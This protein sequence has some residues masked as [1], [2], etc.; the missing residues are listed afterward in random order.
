MKIREI[1]NML[2]RVPLGRPVS[3]STQTFTTREF[4]VVRLTTEQGITGVGYARGGELVRAAVEHELRPLVVG[5]DA[6]ATETLWD[7]VWRR[8]GLVGRRGAV[9]RALSALDIALWDIKAKAAGLPLYQL[10]GGAV[11]SVPAYVSGGYYRDG[12]TEQELA[13]EM[14]GYVERGFRAVKMRVGRLPLRQDVRRVAAVRAA[15]G[16][17]TELMVDAN[18]AYRSSAVAIAAGRAFADEGVSWLEEPLGLEHLAATA[19]VAA[20]LDLPIAGGEVESTRWAFRDIIEQ[21]VYDILQP[22]VTVVGGIS[23]W[24]KVAAL[25]ST[26][27]LA[28]APHYFFEVHAHLVAATPAAVCVEYFYPDSDI[29]TFDPLLAEPLTPTNGVLRLNE[30]PGIGLELD[31]TML[32]RLRVA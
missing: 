13:R 20:A 4:N 19:E 10:L 25:A 6:L 18:Q 17:E 26:W 15:I 21:K 8:T 29:I 23:E 30:R 12:E 14:A 32:A 22:D 1:E 5:R 9:L 2:V 3:T 16:E 24:L 31:D 11:P 28:L 27:S 7:D